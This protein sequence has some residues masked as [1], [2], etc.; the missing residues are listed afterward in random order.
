[1]I[2]SKKWYGL[3]ARTPEEYFYNNCHSYEDISNVIDRKGT[4]ILRD[5]TPAIES[6]M[7]NSNQA[8]PDSFSEKLIRI[9]DCYSKI[10]LK[11]TVRH[12]IDNCPAIESTNDSLWTIWLDM[13]RI[14]HICTLNKV[15]E[16][17]Q[18]ILNH[19][20]SEFADRVVSNLSSF[21]TSK[22]EAAIESFSNNVDYLQMLS[23]DKCRES[24]MDKAPLAAYV[25]DMIVNLTE[26]D[27]PE[28]AI[29]STMSEIDV[30][31][32]SIAERMSN[33][34]VDTEYSAEN[35]R[36]LVNHMWNHFV[37]LESTDDAKVEIVSYYNLRDMTVTPKA[38][39]AA[40]MEMAINNCFPDSIAPALEEASRELCSNWDDNITCS[41]KY[42]DYLTEDIIANY[43]GSALE[44]GFIYMDD[45]DYEELIAS[46]DILM[47]YD[48]LESAKEK[49][50]P[51]KHTG[52]NLRHVVNKVADGAEK[53]GQVASKVGKN[54][55]KGAITA[56]TKIGKA[57]KFFKDHEK[58]ID[59][60]AFKIVR[61]VTDE[62]VGSRDEIREDII[63]GKGHSLSLVLKKIIGGWAVFC[64]SP[65]AFIITA[66]VRFCNHGKIKRSEKKRMVMD[67]ESE[68]KIVDEKIRDA[69]ADGNREAKYQLMRTRNVLT[70]GV[71]RIRAGDEAIRGGI[72]T[73]E[74]SHMKR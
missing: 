54:V 21:T 25:G 34:D 52:E 33:R 45:E 69:E 20:L 19:S 66:M 10:L 30:A 57:F 36:N 23:W 59:A 31:L 53:A 11:D 27:W 4:K 43:L 49:E 71:H 40:I 60:K 63:E 61:K 48:A 14:Q 41:S 44:S 51:E 58:Q 56:K 67:I 73:R 37:A 42:Q 74:I 70:Q 3:T 8:V 50:E 64:V 15:N 39:A 47:D 12:N 35:F 28:L 13:P 17:A 24:V 16:S 9:N 62:I 68:I 7:D 55:K 2:Q 46:D 1:M 29:E 6:F 18:N 26:E 5:I 38:Y 32:E 22:A 65:I 72:G